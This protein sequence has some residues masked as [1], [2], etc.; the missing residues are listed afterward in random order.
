MAG[1]NSKYRAA[2]LNSITVIYIIQRQQGV[3]LYHLTPCAGY[4]RGS[5]YLLIWYSS[6]LLGFY[7]LYAPLLPLLLVSRPTYRR[8]TDTLF[9][10]WEAFNTVSFTLTGFILYCTN[11]LLL[12]GISHG[13]VN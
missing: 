8:L 11:I 9:Q 5:C 4:I 1:S 12:I 6:I 13:I 3:A 2:L 7:F 10:T